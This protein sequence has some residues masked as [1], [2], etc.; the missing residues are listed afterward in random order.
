MPSEGRL[1][2]RRSWPQCAV[3]GEAGH[4]LTGKVISV[5]HPS[6]PTDPSHAVAS[7]QMAG[8]FGGC[9][10]IELASEDA[11]KAL[12]DA[13]TLFRDATSLG[14][15]ESLVE[16]RRKYDDAI[17]PRLLRVSVGLEDVEHLRQDLERAVLEVSR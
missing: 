12:P 2:A 8:G 15:V 7:Q 4:A 11:A 6:L 10:A 5:R 1:S 17:S 3:D 16:W 13:L 9:F 14:G